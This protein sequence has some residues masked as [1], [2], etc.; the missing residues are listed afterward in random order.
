MKK[1]MFVVLLLSL[2]VFTLQAV[3]IPVSIAMEES[4]PYQKELRYHII[5][6]IADIE[7]V[8]I[9]EP[10]T[11]EW[12]RVQV[13]AIEMK[14]E[15]QV[16]VGYAVSYTIVEV[17]FYIHAYVFE[18]LD[19]EKKNEAMDRLINSTVLYHGADLLTVGKGELESVG[20]RIYSSL[21]EII[22]KR[23]RIESR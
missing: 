14:L 9:V 3:E 11:R 20:P 21:S 18:N 22:D 2:G 19:A 16:Q 10:G 6:A 4:L 8:T 23:F 15:N 5:K 13:L 12:F 17:P 1:L 7:N